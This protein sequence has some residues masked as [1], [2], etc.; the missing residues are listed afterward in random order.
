MVGIEKMAHQSQERNFSKSTSSTFK[1]THISLWWLAEF[2]RKST[3]MTWGGGIFF[4][5]AWLSTWVDS[6]CRNFTVQTGCLLVRV[7]WCLFQLGVLDESLI[8]TDQKNLQFLTPLGSNWNFPRKTSGRVFRFS[9]LMV[10][11][12]SPWFSEVPHPISPHLCGEFSKGNPRKY[13]AALGG[14]KIIMARRA[15]VFSFEAK[16]RPSL[17]GILDLT[18]W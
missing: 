13:P 15:M 3:G 7:G 17:L 9:C 10:C 1:K 14:W 11:Y 12:K 18:R 2:R 5:K 16:G 6:C 8:L 4:A